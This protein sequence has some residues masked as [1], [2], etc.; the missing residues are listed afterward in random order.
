M[1]SINPGPAESITTNSQLSVSVPSASVSPGI[2]GT[3]I[4][5]AIA[6]LAAQGGGTLSLS[7]GV[8]YLNAP[9]VMQSGVQIVG[10]APQ[11][12]VSITGG[13]Y[14]AGTLTGVTP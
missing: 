1:T 13:T 6:A 2:V 7:A 10:V 5:V 9:I 8:Y 12:A 11:L 4:N 14:S 3:Q